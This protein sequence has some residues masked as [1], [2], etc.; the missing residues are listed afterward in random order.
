MLGGPSFHPRAAQTRLAHQ[1][2]MGPAWPTRRPWAPATAAGGRPPHSLCPPK[3][4][5]TGVPPNHLCLVLNTAPALLVTPNLFILRC[6]P[7]L[8]GLAIPP[9][10]ITTCMSMN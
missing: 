8:P 2:S 1:T 10:F 9:V 4:W 5:S 6:P 3:F 7:K